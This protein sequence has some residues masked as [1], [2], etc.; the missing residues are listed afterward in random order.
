VSQNHQNKSAYNKLIQVEYI[1]INS[2]NYR[3]EE[4]V[5]Y[6][7]R[8]PSICTINIHN[9]RQNHQLLLDLTDLCDMIFVQE[10][11][12]ASEQELTLKIFEK[13]H[14]CHA[15]SSSV[16]QRQE[17]YWAAMAHQAR[18]QPSGSNQICK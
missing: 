17:L 3:L 16:R 4:W 14:E 9:L 11:W 1:Q 8:A 15:K 7:N 5:D 12:L 2:K 10:T 18:V 13:T 6:K